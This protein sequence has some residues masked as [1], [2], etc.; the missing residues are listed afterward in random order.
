MKKYI[1][2]LMLLCGGY[3]AAL[4]QPAPANAGSDNYTQVI[5]QR[6]AKIVDVLNISDSAKYKKVRDIIVGQYRGLNDIYNDRNAKNKHIKEQLA[7]DKPA[8]ATRMADVDSAVV[9]Q[10]KALHAQYLSKLTAELNADQVD[11]VKDGM[12]YRIY[13]ITYTAYLDEIPSL[14]NLQKDKIKGW[15]LEARENAI[16]AESSEKKHAWF[17][18]FKG[19]INNYLSAQGYDMK[20]EGEEWQKRIKERA[21]A[22]K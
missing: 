16:D 2:M 17:G 8:A 12:T 18:K 9:K 15:L 14:T 1:V 6:A 21:A 4:A 11:K 20:K 3:S 22:N 13:P 7:N 19:R 5:T 10:V